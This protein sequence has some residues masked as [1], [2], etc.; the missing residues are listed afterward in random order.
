LLHNGLLDSD[1]LLDELLHNGL[2]DSDRLLDSNWLLNNNFDR[3]LDHDFNRVRAGHSAFND[4]LDNLGNDNFDVVVAGN[5]NLTRDGDVH[6]DRHGHFHGNI[7]RH[8]D[9]N[10]DVVRTGDIHDDLNGDSDL[11][12]VR[13]G[14]GD[15]NLV[16]AGDGDSNLF[17]GS[18]HF[19]DHFNRPRDSD[20]NL[21]GDID[22]DFIRDSNINSDVPN[23]RHGNGP[24]DRDIVRAGHGNGNLVGHRDANLNRVGLRHGHSNGLRNINEALL[25]NN[26]LAD[27]LNILG[28]LFGDVFDDIVGLVDVAGLAHRNRNFTTF[29]DN[30][31]KGDFD[32]TS[33][34]LRNGN[35]DLAGDRDGNLLNLLDNGLLNNLLLDNGLVSDRLHNTNSLANG[36]GETAV[37]RSSETSVSNTSETSVDTSEAIETGKS[38]TNEAVVEATV[39]RSAETTDNTTVKAGQGSLGGCASD[40]GSNKEK[41]HLYTNGHLVD[42]KVGSV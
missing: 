9:G 24:F 28:D 20:G 18:V 25:R 21:N 3:A 14:H 7:N 36:L 1:R 12:G 35:W 13:A 40:H 22:D 15:S 5:F 27:N 10:L 8:G 16:R 19:P 17:R 4:T 31:G 6:F 41:L 11:N 37:Q 29:D 23:N 33:D 42:V 39:Q 2:L 26:L 38:T 34:Y 30:F 32:F